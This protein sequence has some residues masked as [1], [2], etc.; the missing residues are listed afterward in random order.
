M[1]RDEI[2]RRAVGYILFDHTWNEEE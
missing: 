2:F 1:N